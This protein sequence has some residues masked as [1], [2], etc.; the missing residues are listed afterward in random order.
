MVESCTAKDWSMKAIDRD[1]LHHAAFEQTDM[2]RAQFTKLID[3]MMADK[4]TREP[5][6]PSNWGRL[7]VFGL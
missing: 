5:P 1:V 2:V 6:T 4:M 3:E 7:E